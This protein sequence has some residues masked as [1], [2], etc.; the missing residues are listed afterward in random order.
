[1]GKVDITQTGSDIR[2]VVNGDSGAL[3]IRDPPKGANL[4]GPERIGLRGPSGSVE[5]KG[6]GGANTINLNGDSAD[7]TIGGGDQDGNVTIRNGAGDNAI[8]LKGAGARIEVGGKGQG[9]WI[10]VRNA[11][12][13]NTIVLDGSLGDITLE[14][15]DC[16]EEFDVADA[17]IAGPGTVMVLGQHGHLEESHSAY[18][19]KVAGVVSGAGDLKPGIVLGRQPSPHQRAAVALAGRA[20]CKVDAE[21]ASIEVGDLLTTSPT[22]GHAMKAADPHRAFGAVIGKALRPLPHGQGLIPILIALQ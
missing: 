1:M 4:L 14:H 19:T 10:V 8:F 12:G 16:A 17:Q 5:L 18:D 13:A 21:H 6:D 11:A 22:A 15:A 3:L 9:G 2:I 7:V 20:Y